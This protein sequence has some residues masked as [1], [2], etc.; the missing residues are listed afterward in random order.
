VGAGRGR[1]G[2]PNWPP[3]HALHTVS[4]V[5]SGLGG[6]RGWEGA[7]CPYSDGIWPLFR[8]RQT[9]KKYIILYF[10]YSRLSP[11]PFVV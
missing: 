2:T 11:T 6:V 8:S 1:G 3:T 5:G 10:P 9:S 4:T 7:G